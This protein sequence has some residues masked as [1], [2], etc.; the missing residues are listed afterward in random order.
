[1]SFASDLRRF[2]NTTQKTYNKVL[3]ESILGLT[4]EMVL[5]TPCN[6]GLA[7][8]NY[9]WG[10]QPVSGYNATA[11]SSNGQQSLDAASA[12]A[13][14][15]VAG[16]VCFMS[17]NVPYILDLEYGSSFKAPSGMVRTIIARWP[18]IG[19]DAVARALK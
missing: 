19:A 3:A 11:R 5:L 8:S 16:G 4:R 15:A 13:K 14:R 1:M 2:C 12:F 10:D 17:N 6:T 18:Q 9:L 7:R